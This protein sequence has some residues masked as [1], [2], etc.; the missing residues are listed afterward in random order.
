MNFYSY[1]LY[2][3][4]D[5]AELLWIFLCKFFK[6]FICIW[7]DFYIVFGQRK[8]SLKRFLHSFVFMK[9]FHLNKTVIRITNNP[10]KLL[11]GL[12]TNT[13]N[14]SQ[15]AFLD[16]FGK[17]VTTCDQLKIN[18]DSLFLILESAF[19]EKLITHLQPY[20]LLTRTKIEKE[21][22]FFVYFDLEESYV[23]KENE[24]A[25]RQKKGQ[26]LLTKQ[27]LE[28]SVSEQEFTLFRLKNNIPLQGIDYSNEMLLNVSYDFVS[29]TKG[30]FLGQEVVARVNNLG[31]PPKKLI[32]KYED[33]C[34]EKE[35]AAMTSKCVD[36]NGKIL[37]FVFVG[38]I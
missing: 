36:E 9:L 28:A 1:F 18:D 34:S 38:N 5:N 22:D 14:A 23:P 33:E 20:L 30:C 32:V 16:K 35:K 26:L 11:N 7:L 21:K 6:D 4:L 29:F 12:T 2:F 19:Y 25:I 27:E 3:V 10:A 24:Y 37:G 13:L 17:I 15:T 31:K 8:E